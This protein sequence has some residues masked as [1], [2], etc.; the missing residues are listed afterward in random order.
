MEHN[1]EIR[2]VSTDDICTKVHDTSR[3]SILNANG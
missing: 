3:L 2:C 1:R